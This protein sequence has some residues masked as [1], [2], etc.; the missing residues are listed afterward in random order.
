MLVQPL[1]LETAGDKPVFLDVL[2]FEGGPERIEAGWWDDGDIWRDYYIAQ[3]LQGMR[4]WI[5]R[6]CRESRWYLHGLFG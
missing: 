1:A 3:N 2:D 4:L 6:D 5:F